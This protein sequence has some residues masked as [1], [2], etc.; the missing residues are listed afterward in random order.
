VLKAEKIKAAVKKTKAKKAAEEKAKKAA[1]EN[2]KKSGE[3]EAK[4]APEN[5]FEAFSAKM[6][7]LKLAGIEA[8]NNARKNDE[9]NNGQ[10]KPNQGKSTM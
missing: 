6:N 4:Q 8:N 5:S 10:T 3:E 7:A 2:K 9:Q 1:E